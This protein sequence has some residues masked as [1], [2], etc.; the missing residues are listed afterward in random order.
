MSQ[1]P[2]SAILAPSAT[3][4]SWSGLFCRSVTGSNLTAPL[5]SFPV[6]SLSLTGGTP[7]SVKA[8]ALVVGVAI[9]AKGLV[10]VPPADAVVKALGKGFAGAITGLGATGKAEEVTLVANLGGTGPGVVVVV[11]LGKELAKGAVYD[12]E[13]LRRATGAA[14]RALRG[15]RKVAVALPT[16]SP[17]AV[18]AI[19]EGAVL[20]G[21]TFTAY[22]STSAADHKPPVENVVIVVSDPKDKATKAA[23]TRA[24]VVARAVMLTRDLVN[25]PPSHLHP[26]E[27]AEIA[28]TEGSKAGLSVEVLDEKALRKGGYGGILGV[29]QGSDA[30]PRLVHLTYKGGRGAKTKVA[31]VGKGI[32]FDSGGLSLKPATAMEEMKMDMGGAAAVIA[33]MRAVAELGLKVDV[34]A[35]IPMAENMPSGAAI[36]P[37][38]VLSMRSGLRVE[39]TNT[40]AEGRLILADAIARAAEDKPDVILDIATLTGAQLVALGARTTGVMAND[41]DLRTSV[42]DAATRAGEPSWAMPLPPELRKGLDSEIADLVNSGPRE[43]GM[44]TAGIFLKEFVPEG[45]RWAHLDIAGPAYNSADDYGYTPHGGTGAGVRTFVQFLED[46][47]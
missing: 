2:K 17:D 35:W 44:L 40:D 14:L 30:P 10:L 46:A 4:R 41:D 31:L 38:D 39:V 13:T 1:P 6:T 5:R 37:S 42:V 18:R 11:G 27:L 26:A 34:E 3:C 28:R 47:Q 45:I 23:L 24:D 25:T 43:G 29:G 9:G 8:D 15:N 19:G 33:T 12:G 20:G 21:Y 7:T 16:S 32:T 36:R 22:R